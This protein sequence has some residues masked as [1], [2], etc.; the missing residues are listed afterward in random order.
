MG[1]LQGGLLST[2]AD[3]FR[4]VRM[5]DMRG[6]TNGIRLLQEETIQAMERPRCGCG[7]S[8]LHRII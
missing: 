6:I 3:T 4:F 2:V 8:L 5:L 7:E 1:H